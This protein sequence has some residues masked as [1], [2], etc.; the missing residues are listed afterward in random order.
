EGS[1]DWLGRVE[2]RRGAL[3]PGEHARR[4]PRP[5]QD[6]ESVARDEHEPAARDE[7]TKRLDHRRAPG[8]RTSPQIIAIGEAAGQ[9]H[10][11]ELVELALAVPHVAHGLVE[12]LG[13]DVVKVAVAPRAGEDDATE[14]HDAL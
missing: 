4:Q 6:L 12:H 10:A 2:A 13:D 9:D 8:H 5:A 14:S 3:A 11:V 7:L 1:G